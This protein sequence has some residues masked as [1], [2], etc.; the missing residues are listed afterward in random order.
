[1]LWWNWRLTLHLA[2]MIFGVMTGSWEW[3][4]FGVFAGFVE[5]IATWFDKNLGLR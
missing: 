2:V 1:M 5:H 3:F 4:A